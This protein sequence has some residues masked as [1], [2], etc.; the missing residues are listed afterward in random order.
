M[1]SRN[2]DVEIENMLDNSHYK[3]V[4]GKRNANELESY[5]DVNM[6]RIIFNRTNIPRNTCQEYRSVTK[7]ES[8]ELYHSKLDDYAIYKYFRDGEKIAVTLSQS[9]RSCGRILFRTGIPNI[10]VALIEDHEPFLENKK[11]RTM[12]FDEGLILEA[13]IRGT[14]NS[15]ELSTD[16]LYQ[17]INFRICQAQRQQIITSQA[18]MKQNLENLRDGKGRTLSGHVAGEAAI[19]HRCGLR[20]VKPRRGEMKCCREMPIWYG[21]DFK[22]P[23]FMKPI[24]REVTSICTPRVCNQFTNPL[25]NIGSHSDQK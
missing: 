11:L 18:L 7:I 9:T 1:I 24:S 6:G 17:D 19:I 25:F 10:Y 12:E 4:G 14:M 5:V 13:E 16:M 23:G 21:D 15:I 2:R 8:G 3:S 20:M 22:K